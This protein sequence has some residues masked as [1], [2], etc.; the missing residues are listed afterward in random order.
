MGSS[1]PIVT[2]FSSIPARRDEGTFKH[3]LG[4]SSHGGI[5]VALGRILSW[6]AVCG[7]QPE[8]H[9]DP[10]SVVTLQQSF[11]ASKGRALHL[12]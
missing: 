12:W 11:F 7:G 2:T 5:S 4:V 1:F 8:P 6:A 9:S 3:P 10:A